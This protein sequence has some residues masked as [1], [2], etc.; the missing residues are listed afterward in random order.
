MKKTAFFKGLVIS[1]L[2]AS[3]VG[4]QTAAV[5]PPVEGNS[6]TNLE[7]FRKALEQYRQEKYDVAIP[8]F[9]SLAKEKGTLEEYSRFYLAQSLMKTKK[10]DE[11]E[12]EL[13]KVLA[14]SPNVKMSIEASNLLGQVAEQ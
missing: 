1:L 2:F 9:E 4:A 8:A 14:L 7:A 11:A 10:M 3:T 13:K 6:T 5:T 12:A